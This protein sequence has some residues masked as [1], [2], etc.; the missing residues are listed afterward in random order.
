MAIAGKSVITLPTDSTHLFSN[1]WPDSRSFSYQWELLK[2][3]HGG[4][5]SGRDQKDITL[6][7]VSHLNIHQYY[8]VM[9]HEGCIVHHMTQQCVTA[10]A[11]INFLLLQPCTRAFIWLAALMY[12][13]HVIN[14]RDLLWCCCFFLSLTFSLLRVCIS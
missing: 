14:Y 9:S 1:T 4:T 11:F 5:L 12:N 6:S 3:P 10:Q 8:I 2:G 13:V 7:N